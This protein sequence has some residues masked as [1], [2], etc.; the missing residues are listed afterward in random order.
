MK[1]WH[2]VY[3]QARVPAKGLAVA[4]KTPVVNYYVPSSS[5]RYSH[6]RTLRGIASGATRHSSTDL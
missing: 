3:R 2:G 5:L 4:C 6:R 1:L